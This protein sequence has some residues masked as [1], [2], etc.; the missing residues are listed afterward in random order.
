MGCLSG[1]TAVAMLALGS[2]DLH[3]LWLVVVVTWIIRGRIDGLNHGVMAASVILFHGF[4]TPQI[5]T[6]PELALYFTLTL[7]PLGL[8]HDALQYSHT[9]AHAWLRWFFRNQ[10]LY[11][12]LI[13]L[14]YL[15]LFSRNLEVP[16]SIYT[17]VKGYGFLYD[18][19]RDGWLRRLGIQ[20]PAVE[21]GSAG[22]LVGEE[23]P[24]KKIH[25]P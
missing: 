6:K 22:E 13:A 23:S 18:G 10:H 2:I 3:H 24:E 20:C 8:L 21:Q 14:G 16:I 17:F 12:Y 15:G 9:N 19:R 4:T 5:V 11:W 1:L 7:L 25:S